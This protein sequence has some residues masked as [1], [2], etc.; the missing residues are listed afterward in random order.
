ME[1]LQLDPKKQSLSLITTDIPTIE[2]PDD[3]IIKVAY[4]GICGTD[5][6]II[7][8]SEC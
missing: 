7:E 4:A 5:L 1:A 8:V 3:V 2:K 6:H